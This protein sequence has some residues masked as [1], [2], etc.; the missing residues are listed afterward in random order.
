MNTEHS[1][2]NFVDDSTNLIMTKDPKILQNYLDNFHLLLRNVY[3]TNKLIINQEKTEIMI[4]CKNRHR[5]L[6]KN[7]Q[8]YANEFKIKQVNQVKILGYLIQ[9]NLHND[10]QIGKTISNINN[11]LYNIKK[12]ENQTQF[13]TRRRLVKSIVISKL[14]YALRLL[15]NSTKSQLQKL[16]TLITKSCKVIMGN[17]CFRWS[18]RKMLNKCNLCTIYQLIVEQGLIFIHKIQTTKIPIYLYEM[19]NT[20]DKNTRPK[21]SLR[22]KYKPKTS[23]LKNSLFL[24]FSELYTTI[25]EDIKNIS[26]LK[27][28]KYP[29]RDHITEQYD[30]YSIPNLTNE[31][32]NTLVSE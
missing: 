23:L 12:L 26:E 7:I 2:I 25:P 22:P 4:A 18:T 30:P 21:N 19:Y 11:R 20:N 5:K 8:M 16:N 29:I 15:S 31:N 32:N 14:N 27:F 24:K 1:T 28:V 17:P 9:S 13:K 3:N 6:T 10:L